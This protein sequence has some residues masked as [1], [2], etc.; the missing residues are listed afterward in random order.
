M[1]GEWPLHY[2]QPLYSMVTL[3]PNVS[4]QTWQAVNFGDLQA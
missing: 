1:W 3:Q 4:S 2:Y